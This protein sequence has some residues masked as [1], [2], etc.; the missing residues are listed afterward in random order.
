MAAWEGM[1]WR[2]AA[3]GS[4]KNISSSGQWEGSR[5]SFPWK[6]TLSLLLVLLGAGRS[7]LLSSL[8]CDVGLVC[9]G[10]WGGLRGTVQ[11]SGQHL[12]WGGPVPFCPALSSVSGAAPGP[13]AFASHRE[14]SRSL[15]CSGSD[16]G[17]QTSS[18]TEPGLE[19]LSCSGQ[20]QGKEGKVWRWPWRSLWVAGAKVWGCVGGLCKEKLEK[21]AQGTESPLS[22]GDR[23]NYQ[24]SSWAGPA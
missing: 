1:H 3:G 9:V 13:G 7:H 8:G 16:E 24:L 14:A 10:S 23:V 22:W 12:K 6:A 19:T 5:T 4:G 15:P 20:V 21:R 18:P 2:G 11:E 17:S